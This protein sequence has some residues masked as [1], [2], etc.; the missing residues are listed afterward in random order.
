MASTHRIIGAGIG[1]RLLKSHRFKAWTILMLLSLIA[2]VELKAEDLIKSD[3]SGY[4]YEIDEIRLV[5]NTHLK[6]FEL[7]LLINSTVS[8][9]SPIFGLLDY[10]NTN[11]KRNPYSPVSAVYYLDNL[12]NI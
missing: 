3:Y 8:R 10:Y 7:L 4:L 1:N 2:N 5:G 6:E 9:K 11:M 12:V